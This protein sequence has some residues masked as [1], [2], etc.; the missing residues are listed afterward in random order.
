MAAAAGVGEGVMG[1]I[2]L[3]E[4]VVWSPVRLVS[5]SGGLV[6][7]AGLSAKAARRRSCGADR[8]GSG[9]GRRSRW[10]MMSQT[11]QTRI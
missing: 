10:P 4:R 5:G 6:S 7:L 9:R 2:G 8:G 1:R 3:I 11:M